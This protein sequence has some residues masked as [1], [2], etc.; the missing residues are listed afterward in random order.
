MELL[1]SNLNQWFPKF[2]FSGKITDILEDEK[3][4][5]SFYIVYEHITFEE[6]VDIYIERGQ[7][8]ESLMSVYR[9]FGY[10]PQDVDETQDVILTLVPGSQINQI[11]YNIT[12]KNKVDEVN[13]EFLTSENGF[14]TSIDITG[15]IAT[16]DY[17]I[18]DII[19][20]FVKPRLTKSAHY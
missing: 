3:G 1:N 4:Q 16:D 6:S 9:E 8:R 5:T 18:Y 13:G 15:D 20:R 11:F 17:N 2:S 7:N 12:I 14:E 10:D 19:F